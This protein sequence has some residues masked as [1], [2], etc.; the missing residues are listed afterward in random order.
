MSKIYI[1]IGFVL[2]VGAQ[3]FVPGIMI[4]EQEEALRKGTSYNFKTRPIDPSDPFRGKYITL[5]YE[6][7]S[8][9]STDSIWG[10]SQKVYVYLKTDD[11]GFAEISQVSPK[12]LNDK[13]DYVVA[14]NAGWYNGEVH[15]FLP[16]NRYYM[17]E[18]KAYNAEVSVRNAIRNRDSI[19]P[20]CY[21]KVYILDNVAVLDNVYIGEISVKDLP[22]E[23]E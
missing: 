10:D 13:G 5:S 1:V 15:F 21:A 19:G 17:E 12:I 23:E 7:N 18:T 22:A 8:A 20:E 6:M 16:F 2:M 14:D 11:N 9:E 4:F 3:W